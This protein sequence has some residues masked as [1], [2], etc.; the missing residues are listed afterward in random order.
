LVAHLYFLPTLK[1]TLKN[2]K[3][4]PSH[5]TKDSS[6]QWTETARQTERQHMTAV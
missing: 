5:R 1:P 3:E 6:K 2:P 4:P